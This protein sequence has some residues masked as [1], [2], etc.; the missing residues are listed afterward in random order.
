MTEDLE[1]PYH[2]TCRLHTYLIHYNIVRIGFGTSQ[3]LS[4]LSYSQPKTTLKLLSFAHDSNY[5]FVDAL[6]GLDQESYIV[7]EQ[8]G[9][10]T[11]CVVFLLNSGV[12]DL[13]LSAGATLSVTSGSAA[14]NN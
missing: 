13:A 4:S 7:N 3:L 2:I 11:V 6:I 14:G 1:E 12:G 8:A 9:S 5:C 10:L